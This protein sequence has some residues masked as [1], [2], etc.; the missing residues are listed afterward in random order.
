MVEHHLQHLLGV[1]VQNAAL[2]LT[3]ILDKCHRSFPM[4]VS[5]GMP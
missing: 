2:R 1:L 4:I 3:G 5:I